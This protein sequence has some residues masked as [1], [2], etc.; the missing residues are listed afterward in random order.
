MMYG[1]SFSESLAQALATDL[2]DRYHD[3]PFQLA[4]IQIVVPTKRAC[5][6]LKNAF[7]K[8]APKQALLLPKMNPLYE[9]D[10]LDESI[11]PALDNLQRIAL[12]AKLCEAK[13]NILSYE[14]ALKMAIS[15]TE[16]LDTAYQYD[17]D[18]SNI[19]QLVETEQ[20]ASHWQQT[21]SFL[22]I[23]HTHWPKILA[24][25]GKIDKMDRTV[26]LIRK[27]TEKIK[28][29]PN[30]TIVLAGFNDLFP[31]VKEL[32]QTA[33]Q[34]KNNL[35]LQDN[36]YEE[37]KETPFYTDKHLPQEQ[38]VIQAL[39]QDSW[40][41]I[42]LS[43]KTF[44]NVKLIN[45]NTTTEEALTIALLLRQALETPN[46]TAALVTTD[47]NL[48]RQVISQM[49]RWHIELD[50]SAGTPLNHTSIGLFFQ[51][52]VNVGLKP[53]GENYLALLKHPLA[54]DGLLPTDLRQ[55]IQKQEKMLRQ[56]KRPWEFPLKTDFTDWIQIFQTKETVAFEKIIVKHIE[57]A[58]SLATSADRSAAERLWD[59]DAGKQMYQFLLELKEQSDLIGKIEPKSYPEILKLCMQQIA[60][61][62]RYGT[63]PRLDILGPIEARFHHP[64]VCVIGGLNEGIFPPL[65]ET[66][67][68]L[69]RPMR[70]K[71]ELP[72]PEEKIKTLSLD[73]AHCFCSQQV[74]L[75]RSQ[76][77]DGTQTVPSRFISRLKAVAQ[78]N[79]IKLPEYQANLCVLMD[80]PATYETPL[81][82]APTPPVEVRPTK[83]PVTQIEMWRRNPYAIYARYILKLY[84][85]Q[86]LEKET[87]TSDFGIY[88]HEILE[89]FFKENPQ[90]QDKNI[91]LQTAKE[92]FHSK[93]L[94]ETEIKIMLMKFSAIADFIIAQQMQPNTIQNSQTEEELEHTFDIQGIPFTL[95]G[96][97]DRIDKL[98]NNTF[99]ILD[100][101]TYTPPSKK[102]VIAGYSPQLSLEALL[103]KEQKSCAVSNL[104]YW[105]LSNKKNASKAIQITQTTD[106]T[107]EVI[108]NT[109]K[110]LADMVIAFRNENTPYEVC[111]IPSQA[112]HY[113]DYAHLAR[114]QEWATESEDTPSEDEE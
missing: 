71:L 38:A 55:L 108:E 82:P 25:R 76:K 50:D 83:L 90:S 34:N 60:V 111:P 106:E 9:L 100:Y 105:Y 13:P 40:E 96:T 47:R 32:I 74:Y 54:A 112:P 53:N 102:E 72:S 48:S 15:L 62:P 24:E 64:D 99:G 37:T 18:L 65:P 63:H 30:Q 14:Q 114:M 80:K 31:A 3:N 29:N 78:I 107:N 20:F 91:L 33:N 86:V 28:Q 4:Q 41:N 10:I 49:H 26:R 39:T 1:V 56:K 58:E 69:N 2:L 66:G 89:R 87:Q 94:S 88:I 35:I 59:S 23:L 73:F 81:R 57:L 110:G 103:L 27:F 51:L 16:L 17:L 8:L 12:L 109:K 36:F 11:P 6:T 79:Q 68:W 101:K 7:M 21:V 43:E 52:I 19:N 84:P 42:H 95:Y 61:R 70:Q 104:T 5:L 113:N 77:A 92:V 97:A 22:D 44:E 85:L 46:Q 45:A 67:P 98:E 75:T 93:P